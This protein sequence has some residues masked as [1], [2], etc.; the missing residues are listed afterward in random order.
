MIKTKEKNGKVIEFKPKKKYN[1]L[2]SNN[3]SILI[4][5]Q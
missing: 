3:K 2:S 4:N 1:K 5:K